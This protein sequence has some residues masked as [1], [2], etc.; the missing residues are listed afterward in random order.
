MNAN[1][2]LQLRLDT[3]RKYK[4]NKHLVSNE[5]QIF[6]KSN[7]CFVVHA[8]SQDAAVQGTVAFSSLLS[9]E[10]HTL[11]ALSQGTNKGQIY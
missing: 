7:L 10:P 9:C 11:W 6:N 5:N 2:C 3:N 8:Y 4:G 1:F